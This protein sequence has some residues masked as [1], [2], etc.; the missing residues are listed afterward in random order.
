MAEFAMS[1]YN[2]L[3]REDMMEKRLRLPVKAVTRDFSDITAIC[4]SAGITGAVLMLLFYL[5]V[6]INQTLT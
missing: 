4:I 5:P 2:R 3:D 1:A 6:I